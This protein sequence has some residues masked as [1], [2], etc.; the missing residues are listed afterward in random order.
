MDAAQALATAVAVWLTTQPPQFHSEAKTRQLEAQRGAQLLLDSWELTR[1]R[2]RMWQRLYSGSREGSRLVI[3]PILVAFEAIEEAWQQLHKVLSTI[4][5]S[6]TP[7]PLR[8]AGLRLG[9]A[10]DRCRRAW[11]NR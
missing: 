11:G 6:A 5:A 1:T 7:A 3:G 2:S 10:I 9:L 4:E 8:D